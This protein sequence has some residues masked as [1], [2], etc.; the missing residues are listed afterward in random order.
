M[1]SD[2]APGHLLSISGRDPRFGDWKHIAFVPHALPDTTPVLS[3]IT[4]NAVARARAALAALDSSARRLP[5][6][7]L[8]RRPTIRR[9]AQSTSALE[10]T[11]APLQDVLAADEDD[12]PTGG[13]VHEVIN[14][15][16]AAEHA[17]GWHADGRPLSLSLVMDL[18]A[19]LV[20]GTGSDTAEAGRVR[21]VQVAIGSNK[22][23][24][25]HDARFV[26]RPPGLELEGQVRD[27]LAWMT[28]DHGDEVDPVVAAA[29]AHYQFETLH[30]FNDGNGRIGRLLVVLQ[31]LYAGVLTEPTLTVSPWFEARRADYYDHL[32]GVSTAANWDAWI[33]FFAQG[34][35][36]SAADTERRL[37]DLLAVQASLKQKVREAGLRAEKAMQLVDFAFEQPIFTVAMAGHYL[38]VKFARANQLIGQLGG[39]GVLGP[40]DDAKYNRRFMS[41]DVLAILLR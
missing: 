26:P 15:V 28:A 4:F 30:P 8:L 19:R 34:L 41:P 17:F 35:A 2:A 6:P 40:M 31:L 18:Q 20:K 23:A 21:G 33:R 14:F 16:R 39:A 10:G 1:F 13:A 22:G 5:N 36:A 25:I 3:T 9:E 38:G 7:R 32:L 29:I 12:E 11:Y 24:R 37:S 27:C